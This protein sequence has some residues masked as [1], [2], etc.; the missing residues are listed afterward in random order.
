MKKNINNIIVKS[1]LSEINKIEAFVELICD[2]NNI[3][4]NYY[5]NIL[6]SV[7]EAFTNAVIHGNKNDKNKFVEINFRNTVSGLSFSVKDSGNG[8]DYENISNPIEAETEEESLNGRGLFL[9]RT[10]SD[11]IRFLNNGSEIEMLFK[12]S[13][14]N[15]ELSEKRINAYKSFINSTQLKKSDVRG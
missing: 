15:Q 5:S 3:Y 4:N 1:D 10:L 7:T 8:F 13:S 12:I 14:I 11:Q 2:H 6:M 9:M